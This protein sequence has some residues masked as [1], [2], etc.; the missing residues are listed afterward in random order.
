MPQP[1]SDTANRATPSDCFSN[2][3]VI[4]PSVVNLVALISKFDYGMP[5]MPEKKYPRSETV[6][7]QRGEV[8]WEGGNLYF[9]KWDYHM[10]IEYLDN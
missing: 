6:D 1:V 2:E 7:F 9:P 3:R 5:L 4:L 8:E 10:D